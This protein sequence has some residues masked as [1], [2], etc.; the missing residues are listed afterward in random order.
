MAPGIHIPDICTRITEFT[1]SPRQIPSLRPFA[2]SFNDFQ[3]I[4]PPASA[5]SVCPDSTAVL[6]SFS[7]SRPTNISPRN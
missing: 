1:F 6:L 5:Q 4:H 2:F 7:L 3:Q